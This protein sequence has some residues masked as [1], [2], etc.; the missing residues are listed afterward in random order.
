MT[1][2]FKY[3]GILSIE[4]F[5]NLK[6]VKVLITS[7]S[8]EYIVVTGFGLISSK[9]DIGCKLAKYKLK[10]KIAA[11]NAATH[12]EKKQRKIFLFLGPFLTVLFLLTLFISLYYSN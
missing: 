7:P 12:I 9:L 3:V 2:C 4:T 11:V 10:A 5:S 1:A 8:A 6:A